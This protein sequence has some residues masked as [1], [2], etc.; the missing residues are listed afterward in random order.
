MEFSV[1]LFEHILA[2]ETVPTESFPPIPE[3]AVD[4]R[5]VRLDTR[6]GRLELVHRAK[7]RFLAAITRDIP[8]L[9]AS[10]IRAF[11]T[12]NVEILTEN[13]SSLSAADIVNYNIFI[14]NLMHAGCLD[15]C[16]SGFLIQYI[17]ITYQ[18]VANRK[19]ESLTSEALASMLSIAFGIECADE[20]VSDL[21]LIIIRKILEIGEKC[22]PVIGRQTVECFVQTFRVLL[23]DRGC[24]STNVMFDIASDIVVYREGLDES[25]VMGLDIGMAQNDQERLTDQM[26]SAMS[27]TSMLIALKEAFQRDVE[28]AELGGMRL[29]ENLINRISEFQME[30]EKKNA[31]QSPLPFSTFH[32]MQLRVYQALCYLSPALPV[33]VWRSRIAPSLFGNLLQ[34]S[35]QPDARDY[36]ECLAIYWLSRD[37]ETTDEMIQKSII[38]VLNN[39]SLPSQSIASFVLIGSFL[40]STSQTYTQVL[41]HALIP[42]ISSNISYIRGISQRWLWQSKTQPDTGLHGP[43]IDSL[44]SYMTHNKE[45][46]AM[47]DRLIPIY[48]EWDPVGLI[49]CGEILSAHKS[50]NGEFLPSVIFMEAVKVGVHQSMENNWFYTRDLQQYIENAREEENTLTCDK[51][52]ASGKNSQRKYD[53]QIGCIFPGFSENQESLITRRR[54]EATDLILVTTLVEK[55]VNIAG[56]CRSAEVFGAR[57]LIV[58]SKSILRDSIFT[59]MSVTS[60]QWIEIEQVTVRD[61]VPYLKRMQRDEGYTVVC[62][63]QT[64]NSVSIE[65]YDFPKK[66]LLVLG[67]EK[68]GVDIDYL[69]LMDVCVEIPQKGVI[70]SLNVHVSG[71]LAIWQYNCSQSSRKSV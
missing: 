49:E 21:R 62:L 9:C 43:I 31:P 45:A 23:S 70:R 16:I 12:S 10:Q 15:A 65:E 35:N 40:I 18:F 46:C 58:P 71:A 61:L 64:H 50:A 7:W 6:E 26:Y 8:N 52:V 48:E 67:N 2:L 27:R 56:L 13:F 68:N 37:S 66:T 17:H 41:G 32:R 57:K 38:P 19:K 1:D 28:L 51:D 39:H 29:V 20:K 42:Y 53:P 14:Q 24:H 59:T 33:T 44:L 22:N 4:S 25:D 3:V 47:R 11:I 54:V 30:T 36:L 60:E 55:T 69:P 5:F 63:E 34:W